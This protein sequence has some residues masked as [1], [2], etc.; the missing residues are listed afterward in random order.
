MKENF[1]LLS[2]AYKETHWL[3]YPQGTTKVYSYLE[4]RGG[5]YSE[6]LFFGLQMWLKKYFTGVVVEQWMIDE[7][8]SELKEV[9]GCDY[10]NREGWQHIVDVHGGQLPLK[11]KAV[12][13]GTILG[14]KN[15]LVTVE[16]TDPEVPWLTNFCETLLLQVWNTITVSTNSLMSKRVIQ[17]WAEIS[18]DTG[19]SPFHLND[20]GFRGVSSVESAGLAGCAHLV[21]FAGTDTLIAINYAKRFYNATGLVG[22]SVF[23]SEH[24]T[25]TIYGRENEL[26]AYRTF[27]TNCSEGIASLVSDSYNIYE[28]IKMFGTELKE[29]VLSRGSKTG[30]GKLVVRPDSGD[31]V[32]MSLEC[33]LLLD[34]Y[35]GSTTN[36]KGYKVL[37]PKVGVIYGDGITTETIDLI[38]ENLVKNGYSTDNIVF[39]QGGALLQQVNRDTLKFAFKCCYAE[40]N[41]K[42]VDVYKDPITDSGKKSKR[43]K[44]KLAKVTEHF[45][46]DNLP[47]GTYVT[48]PEGSWVKDELVTVFENGELVKD[49]TFTEVRENAGF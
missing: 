37:N 38:L 22:A 39:G 46:P 23:A 48:V 40:I 3:Q 30:F 12:P 2:D 36:T 16:N 32:S 26:E 14:G 45:N 20:F 49:W 43:G 31:P 17:K 11:I 15:V 34:Q 44:L 27:L 4:S 18:S 6:T 47:L 24:S 5:K 35:F 42:G 19:V 7:A 1:I 13:E 10:F 25:T 9:F 21:N 33:V 29:L 28:A 8:D 41:G